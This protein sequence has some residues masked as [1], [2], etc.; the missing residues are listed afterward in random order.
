MVFEGVTFLPQKIKIQLIQS[1]ESWLIC[2]LDIE[3]AYGHVNRNF[4]CSL[5]G[6]MGFGGKWIG[7]IKWCISTTTFSVL[8]NGIPT[9]FFRSSRGLKGG[10]LSPYLS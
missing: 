2:K 5:I 6:K 9:G 10:P 1:C 8:L 4:L 3:R 7:W